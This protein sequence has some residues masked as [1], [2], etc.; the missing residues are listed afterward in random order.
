MSNLRAYLTT[1][2][3]VSRQQA[4]LGQMYR[5]WRALKQ[6]PLALIGLGIVVVLCSSRCWHRS[7]RLMILWPR[8]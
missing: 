3:P 4:R 5:Q 2:T 1:E 6:N 7:L 8:I